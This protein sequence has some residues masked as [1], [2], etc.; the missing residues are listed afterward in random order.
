MCVCA[1]VCGG[2]ICRCAGV[3]VCVTV[4]E[5]VLGNSETNKI[6]I[7]CTYYFFAITHHLI[8]R[9][10]LGYWEANNIKITLIKIETQFFLLQTRKEKGEEG[11][12]WVRGFVPFGEKGEDAGSEIGIACVWVCMSVWVCTSVCVSV[13]VYMSMCCVVV[14]VYREKKKG[15][16][17]SSENNP[18]QLL[19][20]AQLLVILG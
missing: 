15:K 1:C 12:I 7:Q 16:K 8:L 6:K 13:C 10:I 17:N 2:V 20:V 19:L 11:N 18:Y 3:C 5:C 14:R 4:S 9:Y